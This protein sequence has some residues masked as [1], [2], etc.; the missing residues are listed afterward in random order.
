MF[1]KNLGSKLKKFAKI[2]TWVLVILMIGVA[3]LCAYQLIQGNQLDVINNGRVVNHISYWVPL[4]MSLIGIVLSYVTFLPMHAIGDLLET[5]QPMMTDMKEMSN[6]LGAIEKGLAEYEDHPVVVENETP[7]VAEPVV[8]DSTKVFD[9][10]KKEPV[11]EDAE[12]ETPAIVPTPVE[13]KKEEPPVVAEPEVE[14]KEEEPKAEPVAEAPITQ[15]EEED[16]VD[17]ILNDV[18][19]AP[20]KEEA[21]VEASEDDDLSF[22]DLISKFSPSPEEIRNGFKDELFKALQTKYHMN[23]KAFDYML[24]NTLHVILRKDELELTVKDTDTNNV[25]ITVPTTGFTTGLESLANFKECLGLFYNIQT[26][27]AENGIF[28]K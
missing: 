16:I 12:V 6:R 11:T 21:P 14:P 15:T 25:K 13:E 23:Q 19:D 3:G 18:P 5:M 26:A 28:D 2:F 4:V 22:A 20:K 7:A 8:D 27:N 24:K 1:Y 17:K 9:P 10:P